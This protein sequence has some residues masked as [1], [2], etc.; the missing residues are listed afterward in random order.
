MLNAT[1]PAYQI[2]CAAFNQKLSFLFI[3][4]NINERLRHD[5]PEVITINIV[6]GVIAFPLCYPTVYFDASRLDESQSMN[7]FSI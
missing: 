7:H 3:A 6:S 1:F 5:M 4:L 2:A